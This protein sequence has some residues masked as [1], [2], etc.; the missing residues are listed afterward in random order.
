MMVR[1]V[2][3]NCNKIVQVLHLEVDFFHLYALV[4]DESLAE[5]QTIMNAATHPLM[6]KDTG[7]LTKTGMLNAVSTS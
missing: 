2:L 3:I 6:A 1:F 4:L 7:E 5:M